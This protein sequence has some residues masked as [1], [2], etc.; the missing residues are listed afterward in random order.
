MDRRDLELL[1][2]QMTHIAPA[3]RG[4]GVLMLAIA[5]VFFAGIA[6]GDTLSARQSKP[7]PLQTAAVSLPAAPLA[8]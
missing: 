8:R 4:T 5:A 6:V 3:P 2:K 1:D 7:P